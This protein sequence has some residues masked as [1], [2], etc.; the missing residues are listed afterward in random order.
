VRTNRLLRAATI[1]ILA[2]AL[3]APGASASTTVEVERASGINLDTLAFG[4]TAA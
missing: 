4:V 1:A 2:A 3:A